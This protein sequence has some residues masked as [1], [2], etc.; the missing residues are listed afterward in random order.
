LNLP[1]S[2]QTQAADSR[3]ENVVTVRDDHPFSQ[4][5]ASL[6]LSFFSKKKL[7]DVKKVIFHRRIV[8]KLAK[9]CKKKRPRIG[10]E[11]TLFR[12]LLNHTNKAL[13]ISTYSPYGT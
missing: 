7:S 11:P 4:L 13:G 9:A 12:P 10:F 5:G 2:L 1:D 3:K 6:R 8:D